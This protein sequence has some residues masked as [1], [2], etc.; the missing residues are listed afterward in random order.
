M[1]KHVLI[2]I[3]AAAILSTAAQAQKPVTIEARGRAPIAKYFGQASEKAEANARANLFDMLGHVKVNGTSVHDAV[4]KNPELNESVARYT[5]LAKVTSRSLVVDKQYA[6]ARIVVTLGEDFYR[7]F[8]TPTMVAAQEGTAD[9]STSTKGSVM[10]I[11]VTGDAPIGFGYANASL[12]A[13]ANARRQL[14]QHIDTLTVGGKKLHDLINNEAKQQLVTEY[15]NKAKVIS[16]RIWIDR[17]VAVVT[18]QLTL[19]NQFFAINN[20]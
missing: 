7:M 11:E 13:E 14:A 9:E 18:L 12:A 5:R 6:E 3:A 16:R 10:T 20:R 15:L 4:S 2:T 8:G 1:F 19:D 17:K